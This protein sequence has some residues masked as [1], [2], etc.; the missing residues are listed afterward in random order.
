MIPSTEGQTDGRTDKNLGLTN[1]H[2]NGSNLY[3]PQTQEGKV[4]M[5]PIL[6]HLIPLIF[7]YML[8]W[9]HKR[10][11][12]GLNWQGKTS[13]CDEIPEKPGISFPA[14][15]QDHGGRGEAGWQPGTALP[16]WQRCCR[17][18]STVLPLVNM[19]ESMNLLD[20]LR[21]SRGKYR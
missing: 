21:H 16:L 18:I 12:G 8:L 14:S 7:V 1:V 4:Q 3:T 10:F 2:L 19:L 5:K 11:P 17:R 13:I 9:C 6:L 15:S 20:T